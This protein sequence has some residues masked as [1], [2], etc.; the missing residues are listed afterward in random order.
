LALLLSQGAASAQVFAG[1]A[2]RVGDVPPAGAEGD[3]LVS[4]SARFSSPAAIDLSAVN[5]TITSILGEGAAGG[6]GELVTGTG[7]VA[8]VPLTLPPRIGSRDVSAIYVTAGTLRPSVRATIRR[9]ADGTYQLNLK[10]NRATIPAGPAL[11]TGD[12]STTTLTTAVSLSDG[13]NPPVFTQSFDAAW[14]CN[15]SRLRVAPPGPAPTPVPGIPLARLRV[16]QITRETGEP[17]VVELD[18]SLSSDSDGTIASYTF[19]VV[20]LATDAVVFGP[21]TVATPT[22]Q[23]TLPPGDYRASLTV[24]DNDDK[25]STP[26]SRGFTLH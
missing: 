20:D 13:V 1:K 5:L 25:E 23:T 15:G 17:N 16:E 6:A 9:R 21:S 7:G 26:A 3:S 24:K 14:L 8:L 12:P 10:I 19:A 4:V 18:G 11:C 2:T 22:V